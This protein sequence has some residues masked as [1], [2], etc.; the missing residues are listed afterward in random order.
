MRPATTARRRFAFR[1]DRLPS[2]AEYYR[3]Q[4]LKLT[5]AGEWQSARCPFHID[6]NPSLR[7]RLNRGAFR[8]MTCGARA[9]DVL[10]FHRQ[11]YHLSFIEAAK[12]L[13]AWESER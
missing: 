3:K 4:G 12:A 2:P 11:R 7:V 1:R 8:C 5:G 9:G 13:G 6:A 10:D